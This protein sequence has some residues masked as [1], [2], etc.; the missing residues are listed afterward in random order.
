M[1]QSR[2]STDQVEVS[3]AYRRVCLRKWQDR[4]RR[5]SGNGQRKGDAMA[6]RRGT[7]PSG[8]RHSQGIR[9]RRCAGVA[10][11]AASSPT[12]APSTAIGKGQRKEQSRR[13]RQTDCPSSSSLPSPSPRD[14]A[15]GCQKHDQC[16]QPARRRRR[17]FEGG[18]TPRHASGGCSGGDR[19]REI[20]C[21]TAR[22]HGIG[23][24]VAYC[25]GGCTCA[26]EAH[27][28]IETAQAAHLQCIVRRLSRRDASC[29][30]RTRTC[31]QREVLSRTA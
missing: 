21:G 3:R 6:G 18:S 12:A 11:A 22:R 28:L 5:Q 27:A 10:R 24:D 16:R 20:R 1:L 29:S 14:P 23:R 13:E 30:G 15:H 19:D 25:L 26:G 9:S 17:W 8:A 31:R 7:R 2:V 4:A